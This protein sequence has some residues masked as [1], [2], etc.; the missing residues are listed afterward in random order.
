LPKLRLKTPAKK[1]LASLP[2]D[3]QRELDVAL[4]QLQANPTEAGR[5][6]RGIYAGRW[7]MAVGK[8]RIIYR[9][10]EGGNLVIVEAIRHRG[11]DPYARKGS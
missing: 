7:R 1:R 9:I 3:V 6:L 5:P 4:L 11:H 2:A 8:S 10:R